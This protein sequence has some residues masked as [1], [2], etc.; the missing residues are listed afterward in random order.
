MTAATTAWISCGASAT[1]LLLVL[2]V[3]CGGHPPHLADVRIVGNRAIP[4]GELVPALGLTRDLDEGRPVDPYAVTEDTNRIRA[5][6]LR[7]GFFNV[8]V[9]PRIERTLVVF[10]VVE[11]ARATVQLATP[12]LPPEIT[13]ERARELIALRDG[14][15]FDY[16]AY[17]AAK[18]KLLAALEN[19]GYARVVLEPSVDPDPAGA[20]ARVTYAVIA[21]P[22]CVFGEVQYPPNMSPALRDAAA[23]RITFARGEPYTRTALEASQAALYE[24]G[25][26]T[27]VHLVPAGT[28]GVVDV[29]LDASESTRHEVHAG[30]GLGYE[31][32]TYEVRVRGGGSYVPADHPLWTLALD[33]R[34]AVTTPHNFDVDQLEPKFKV[35]GTVQR[36]DLWRPRLHADIEGGADYQTIEAY[37]WQGPHVQLGLGSPLG[38]D[39]LQGAASWQ[40][41]YLTFSSLSPAVDAATAHELRL[42]RAQ[43]RGAFN[44]SL[45]ADGRDDKLD[46]HDGAYFELRLAEGTPAA[47]GDLTYFEV[48]PEGRGFLSLGK[49][50]IAV[51]ARYA[52][53]FGD[54]PPTERFYGGGA[55]GHRG[56]SE[57]RLSPVATNTVDGNLESV[58]IGGAG[59]IDTSVDV[60]QPIFTLGV[61][62]G[63]EVFLDGGDVT[64]KPGDLDPLH[65]HWATGAGLYAD[66]GGF[67]L[68][69][70]VGYRLNRKGPGEPSPDSGTFAYFAWHIGL[71][72]PF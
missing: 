23:G 10:D 42:D 47:G 66:I 54:V 34:I 20:V 69:A 5:A 45:I 58:V 43:Q 38:V 57:R 4:T 65:L 68:R 56:F 28:A 16:D 59:Q 31:P 67:K 51:R 7:R 53:I 3:A 52:A 26:F 49:T 1:R 19:A 72:D 35:L 15:P 18:P 41:E 32:E 17:D 61:P 39:W 40:L 62:F 24:L 60:R 63:L 2:A 33:G 6:Y 30:G 29:R 8:R 13:P 44:Q 21:G 25:R 71:G 9:T 11:G 64:L 37:T 55:Y 14:E 36:L 27:S 46:P 22:R 12:G 50:V 48:V 70:D